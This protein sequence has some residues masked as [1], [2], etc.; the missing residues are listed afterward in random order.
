VIRPA[1]FFVAYVVMM[2]A[3]FADAAALLPRWA[4]PLLLYVPAA[5]IAA[6][7]LAHARIPPRLPRNP[8]WYVA[9]GV[10]ALAQFASPFLGVVLF[11]A[12]FVALP[13]LAIVKPL[14]VLTVAL[15]LLRVSPRVGDLHSAQL[16]PGFTAFLAFTALI[17]SSLAIVRDLA[18]AGATHPMIEKVP[19]PMANFVAAAILAAAFILF[20]GIRRRS[21]QPSPAR[22]WLVPG[23]VLWFASAVAMHFPVTRDYAFHGLV[24]GHLLLFI[25]ATYLLSHLLPR[26]EADELA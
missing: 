4:N 10:L 5:L 21:L 8:G 12:P 16:M 17:H 15:V 13:Y 26:R 24:A 7:V 18:A 20:T 6:G 2:V 11:A 19:G 22:A 14:L 3:T 23:I 1:L 25:G 9:L